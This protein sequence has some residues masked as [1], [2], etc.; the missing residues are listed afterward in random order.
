[1]ENAKLSSLGDLTQASSDRVVGL[2]GVAIVSQADNPLD[3]LD[4]D[5][6][7][8]VFSGAVHDWS[9]V[10]GGGSGP[11]SVFARDEKSGTWETFRDKVLKPHNVDLHA[12]KRFEDSNEL[13]S[14]VRDT[15]GAIGFIGMPYAKN[16][17]NLGVSYRG[18]SPL[19]ATP[20]TVR[21]HTYPIW[22]RLHLYVPTAAPPAAKEFAEFALSSKANDLI[23][24]DA[25]VSLS[26]EPTQV[27][28]PAQYPP[29]AQGAEVIYNLFFR[30]GRSELE[31][32]ALDNLNRVVELLN[33]PENHDAKILLFG[34]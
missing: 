17:K 6:L 34:H 5:Q 13:A 20:L 1:E 29:A 10:P 4:L 22:R 33:R 15:R 18:M 8:Q 23:E 3:S 14:T 32:E 19:M 24:K 27:K 25:F 26:P 31:P 16:L 30:T 9:E 12:T 21:L 7:A 2:D 11:I 28:V